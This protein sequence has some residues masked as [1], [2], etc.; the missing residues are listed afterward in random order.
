M[1]YKQCTKIARRAANVVKDKSLWQ[2]AY[3]TVL[4][5]LMDK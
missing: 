4:Q 1:T 2:I 5:H 3:Y